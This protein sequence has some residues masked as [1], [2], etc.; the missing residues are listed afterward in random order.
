L[1]EPI[2]SG[3]KFSVILYR[4]RL[5]KPNPL[6]LP[7]SVELEDVGEERETKAS[8]GRERESPSRASCSKNAGAWAR[9]S[10]IVAHAVS[11]PPAAP[12]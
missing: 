3:T 5:L 7:R 4:R 6:G 2:T 12:R 8:K 1:N 11:S 10:A 9:R